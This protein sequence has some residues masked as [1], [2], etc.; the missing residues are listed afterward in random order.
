M[1]D[2]IFHAALRSLVLMGLGA[3]LWPLLPT[4]GAVGKR[5]LLLIGMALLLVTPFL[6]TAFGTLPSE[7]AI[8]VTA[9]TNDTSISPFS[10]LWMVGSMSLICHLAWRAWQLGRIIRAARDCGSMDLA[11]CELR[12]KESADVESPCVTGWPQAI[13]LVPGNFSAWDER[14]WKCILWHER[15]HAVQ[16]DVAALWLV[17]IVRALYW[18]NPLVHL[19]ARQFHIE[20]EATCDTAVLRAGNSPRDYV[21]TLL[22]FTSNS[23]SPS[24][25]LT[26][27]SPLRRRI[28][29]FLSTPNGPNNRWRLMFGITSL[30]VVACFSA[31][32]GIKHPTPTPPQTSVQSQSEVEVETRWSANP[33]PSSEAGDSAAV[34]TDQ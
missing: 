17:R 23:P 31:F 24:L 28:E 18:W 25:A 19:A 16:H 2:F 4:G 30:A 3:A 11:G 1:S 34:S 12:I 26:G 13:L 15:Q 27:R 29:R 33:F 14:R 21:E 10:L 6:P 22:S 9:A 8:A 5:R 20:S 7:S 32:C